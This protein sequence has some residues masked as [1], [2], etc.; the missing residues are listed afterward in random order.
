MNRSYT[1]KIVAFNLSI[2]TLTK[3]INFRLVDIQKDCL[4]KDNGILEYNKCGWFRIIDNSHS[5]K[6]LDFCIPLEYSEY[7]KNIEQNLLNLDIGD[8]ICLKLESINE[9]NT[10][11]I[12]NSII[13]SKDSTSP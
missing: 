11:W 10:L 7:N 12:V 5:K 3:N 2:M 13:Q 8:K 1:N 6:G 9:R 4:I